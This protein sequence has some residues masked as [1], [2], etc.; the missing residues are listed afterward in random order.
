[1][2]K[3]KTELEAGPCEPPK[4]D[5][6]PACLHNRDL[7][8]RLRA[9]IERLKNG[10]VL[11]TGKLSAALYRFESSREKQDLFA[12]HLCVIAMADDIKEALKDLKTGEKIEERE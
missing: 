6:C 3:T 8:S 10:A 1:M 9:E 11:A 4:E 7:V 5:G 12:W 2:T